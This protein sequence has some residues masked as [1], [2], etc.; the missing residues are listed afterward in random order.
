[1]M[2]LRL[3]GDCFHAL[4]LALLNAGLKPFVYVGKGEV[5]PIASREGRE[6]EQKSIKFGLDADNKIKCT[7]LGMNK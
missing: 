7:E 1:M 5:H 2:M 4:R 3:Q 6:G